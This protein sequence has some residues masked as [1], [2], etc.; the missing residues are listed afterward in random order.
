MRLSSRPLA[1]ALSSD[2]G[3]RAN[4]VTCFVTYPHVCP[5]GHA[6]AGVALRGGRRLGISVTVGYFVT[7]SMSPPDMH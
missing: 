3:L 7:L 6:L 4:I 2:V 1:Y 5:C